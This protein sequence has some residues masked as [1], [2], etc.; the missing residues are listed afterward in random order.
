MQTAYHSELDDYLRG[1]IGRAKTG[2]MHGGGAMDTSVRHSKGQERA[3]LTLSID[4]KNRSVQIR[5][6]K[7]GTKYS[8]VRVSLVDF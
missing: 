7:S 4:L 2:S 3:G 5:C 1:Q 8:P 6:T